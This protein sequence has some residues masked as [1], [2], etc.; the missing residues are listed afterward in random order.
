MEIHFSL[1]PLVLC[2]PPLSHFKGERVFSLTSP[3]FQHLFEIAYNFPNT[4]KTALRS[5]RGYIN[6]SVAAYLSL[7]VHIHYFILCTCRFQGIM[8]IYP[9]PVPVSWCRGHSKFVFGDY[10]PA[11][12]LLCTRLTRAM[13]ITAL[14]GFFGLLVPSPCGLIGV[15]GVFNLSFTF[16]QPTAV[17]GTAF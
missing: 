14:F 9:V 13:A 15:F 10:S 12:A 11:A 17:V 8:M 5:H 6:V 7:F 3:W 1:L 2:W 4:I 16:S